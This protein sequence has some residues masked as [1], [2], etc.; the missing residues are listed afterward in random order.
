MSPH[1]FLCGLR[2]WHTYSNILKLTELL[3]YKAEIVVKKEGIV[4]HRE[5]KAFGKTGLEKLENAGILYKNS[6]KT[7]AEV[8]EIADVER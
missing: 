5:S 7:A 2:L 3:I 1:S 8:C 6:D 4:I